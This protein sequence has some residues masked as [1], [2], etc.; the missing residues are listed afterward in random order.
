ML[1]KRTKR[2]L[3]GG[4][5]ITM[6]LLLAACGTSTVTQSS[7]NWWDRYVIYNAALFI[8]WLAKLFGG[9]PGVGIIVFTLLIRVVIFPLSYMQIK[10]MGKQQELA[11]QLKELQKQY[12]S[13]DTETQRKLQEATQKLYAD[14]GINPLMG[15]LPLL[16]QMPFLFALYQA[17]ARTDALKQGTFLW[18]NLAKPDPLFILPILAAIFTA[19]TTLT[20]TL[21]QPQR[22]ATSWIM[23]A[24]SPIMILAIAFTMPSAISIYWVVTN[25]FSLAQTFLIQNP[26]KLKRE[27][28]AKAAAEKAR[29]K[30]LRKAYKRALKK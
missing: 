10:S 23:V 20:S 13:K 27:R 7:T 5:L 16:V 17:I 22:T 1:S 29:Q 24:V 30:A 8:L 15:C 28:D 26:F 21:A 18:M 12:S 9:N 11:P 4:G 6:M 14:N 3:L 19:L 2:I 25:A